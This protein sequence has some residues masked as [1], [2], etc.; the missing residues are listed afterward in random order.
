MEQMGAEEGAEVLVPPLSRCTD[1]AA[2]I[3]YAGWLRLR[4][5][6]RDPWTLNASADLPLGSRRAPA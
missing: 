3:A 6:E 1:N 4:R 5:G 2:M